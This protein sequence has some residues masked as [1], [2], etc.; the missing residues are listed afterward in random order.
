MKER[1]LIHR[2]KLAS[3]GVFV[4]ALLAGAKIWNLISH[5]ASV[6]E[7]EVSVSDAKPVDQPVSPPQPKMIRFP[8]LE[9][10]EPMEG[11]YNQDGHLWQLVNKQKPLQ[12]AQYRPADLALA[13]VPSRT[14]KSEEERSVRQ[15]IMPALEEL[16]KD[17]AAA[18]HNLMIGS[19]F[20]SYNLQNMYYSNYVRSYGVAAADRFSAKPGQSE[21]Q[22]GLVVDLAYQNRHCYLDN[23]FAATEAGQWLATNAHKYGFILRYPLGKEEITG[24]MYESWHFRFVGKDLAEA[25]FQSDLTLEEAQDFINNP[26]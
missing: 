4:L 10:I 9:P 6:G 23:C 18:G 16:F 25:L 20:R 13:T 22:T 19:G 7:P 8:N 26:T 1:L 17:A 14:D 2:L 24:Y 3:F 5:R 15:V 12:D 21:H 11:D